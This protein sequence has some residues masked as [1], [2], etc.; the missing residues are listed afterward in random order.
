MNE[1]ADKV[2][3]VSINWAM[4][5]ARIYET[6]PLTC[7]SCGEKITILSF[8]THPEEIWRIL[9]GTI[10]PLEAPEFDPPYELDHWNICQLM[11][12]TLDEIGR[13][14]V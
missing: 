13:A 14:H 9:R 1:A 6:D 10:W 3:K 12:G 7:T 11:P 2:K 5:I 4:L 8:V